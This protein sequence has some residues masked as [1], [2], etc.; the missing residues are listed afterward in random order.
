MHPDPTQA[1]E[2]DDDLRPEY[3]LT[4]LVRNGVRG[5]YAARLAGGSTMVVL[6][7]DVA[8]A[9]PTNE[10]VNEALRLVIRLAAIPA[11]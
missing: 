10:A 7:P 2:D 11:P 6:D 3:D 5:K 4:A 8:A 1:G 9:F